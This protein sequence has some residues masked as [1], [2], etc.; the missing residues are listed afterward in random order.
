MEYSFRNTLP[1]EQLLADRI[2]SLFGTARVIM[3]GVLGQRRKKLI[4]VAENDPS[5]LQM[6][7]SL[8]WKM[9]RYCEVVRFTN[10]INALA[11]VCARQPD[12]I[13]ASPSMSCVNGVRLIDHLKMDRDTR[14]IPVLLSTSL[15][16]PA[17]FATLLANAGNK[18]HGALG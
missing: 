8:L 11:A 16:R 18:F 2:N 10:G 3:S 4:L 17:L 14:R 7:E 6:I 15:S 13:I 5:S 1:G 9:D 12:L